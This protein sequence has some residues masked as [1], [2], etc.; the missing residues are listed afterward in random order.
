MRH[1]TR[2]IGGLAQVY[3]CEQRERAPGQDNSDAKNYAKTYFYA[4][5]PRIYVY[6]SIVQPA[7]IDCIMHMR[8]C[9]KKRACHR[10]FR[11]YPLA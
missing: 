3:I 9:M 11:Y 1:I 4:H 10:Y 8:R 7:S 5:F 2:S 6:I